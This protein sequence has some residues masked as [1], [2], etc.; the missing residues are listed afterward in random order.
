MMY[1]SPHRIADTLRGLLTASS[2]PE[3]GGLT[4]RVVAVDAV[5]GRRGRGGA[6]DARAGRGGGEKE[7]ELTKDR[8]K[9][10]VE[11]VAAGNRCA[12]CSRVSYWGLAGATI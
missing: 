4:S 9:S 11:D 3:E 7:E 5:A 2:V 1:E 8:D 12:V 6:V 10:A